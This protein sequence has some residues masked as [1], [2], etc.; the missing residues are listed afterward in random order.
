MGDTPPPVLTLQVKK[1]RRGGG[2]LQWRAGAMLRVGRV[3]TGNDLAVRDAGAS[4]RH[5]SIEFLPP[6]ASRW[7]VSDVGSSNGTLLNGAPLVPTVP[8]PLSD[9]DVIK[10]GESTV[11]A[12][13]I[14][15]DSDPNPGPRRSSRQSTAVV[16][17]QEKPPAVT[18]RG[19]RKNAA[20]GAEPPDAEKEKP[21]PEE[22]PVVTR[23]GAQKKA[24]EPPKEENREKGKDE[25][26]EKEDEEKEVAVVTR[27]GGR[28]KAAKPPKAEEHE[29][30]KDVE[31][32]EKDEGG[33]DEEEEVAVVTRRGGRRKAAPEAALPPPPPRT[34]STRAA[35]RRGQAVD[36][37]LDEGE[38]EMAGKGRGKV[39]RSSA[40][41][42]RSAVLEDDDGGE[43]QE[44]AMAAAEEQIGNQLMATAA[45]EGEE[46]EDKVEVVDG[47]VEQSV[48]ASEAEEV[49]VARRERARR[50]PKGR[51]KAECAASDN[52]GQEEDGGRGEE[53]D[54]KEESA[55][56]S[57]LETMTLREWFERMNEYLPRVINEA[58]EE[59]LAALRERHRRI[60]EYI[61]TLED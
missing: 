58:A 28:K 17:E 33:D 47:E 5:L 61:S 32:E 46:K 15:P 25:E 11:L 18:R 34:R 59:A 49:P 27:R 44:G 53:V 56:R 40:R 52:G 29:K 51:A 2:T 38:S 57:S 12:V 9:G 8:S 31:E 36:T 16:A 13:S 6:P 1:G 26:Q 48:K 60:D 42:A 55:G 43:Q 35:A 14:V 24:V 21:E 54:E 41:N 45:M 37:C 7:A 20:A 4:Q 3:A 39:T 30:G 22:A 50:A 23:R 10:I 19:G